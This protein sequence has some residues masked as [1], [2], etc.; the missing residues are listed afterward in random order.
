ML[1]VDLLMSSVHMFSGHAGCGCIGEYCIPLLE[2]HSK[3]KACMQ[4][5]DNVV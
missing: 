5:S 2:P 3:L 1:A 4:C